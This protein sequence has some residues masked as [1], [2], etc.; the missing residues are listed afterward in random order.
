MRRLLFLFLFASNFISPFP[1]KS[2]AWAW[3]GFNYDRYVPLNIVGAAQFKGVLDSDLLPKALKIMQEWHPTLA[4]SASYDQN[5]RDW[6]LQ[7][8]DR[9]IPLHI[10]ERTSDMHWQTIMAD[11]LDSKLPAEHGP[12]ARVIYCKG[13]DCGEL[14]VTLHHSLSDGLSRTYFMFELFK[15]MDDLKH[16]RVI[17]SITDHFLDLNYYDLYDNEYKDFSDRAVNTHPKDV[18]NYK[19]FFIPFCFTEEETALIQKKYRACGSSLQ[20][21]LSATVAKAVAQRRCKRGDDKPFKIFCHNPINIRPYFNKNLSGHD[22][23]D[24][25]SGVDTE[26][27]IDASV[28]MIT[29][30]KEIKE[31]L[32]LGLT[33]KKH[34]NFLQNIDRFIKTTNF[35]P[36]QIFHT[37]QVD[38][39]VAAVSQLGTL[40]FPA[41]YGDVTVER[42]YGLFNWRG[43]FVHEDTFIM[44]GAIFQNQLMGMFACI[45]PLVSRTDAYEMS[46]YIKSMLL[47]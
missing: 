21:I 39:P 17:E 42:L 16:N 20:T 43:C 35:T 8:S 38:H 9:K 6:I 31:Q 29:L 7:K 19:V 26:H 10:V 47:N 23:G 37:A 40:D 4:C 30:S 12:F 32:Y 28:D 36:E 44:T 15:I 27:A 2:E 3:I 18:S 5:S 41:T 13:E 22:F 11:E 24:W 14:I 25:V 46:A 33:K 34:L 1:K 45:E